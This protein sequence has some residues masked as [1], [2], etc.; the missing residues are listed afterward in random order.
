MIKKSSIDG[1]VQTTLIE[2]SVLI[3]VALFGTHW[4]RFVGLDNTGQAYCTGPMEADGLAE[5]EVWNHFQAEP[6]NAAYTFLQVYIYIYVCKTHVLR[7]HLVSVWTTGLRDLAKLGGVAGSE[8]QRS[9]ARRPF[10]AFSRLRTLD[11]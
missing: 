6:K 9:E 7:T 2:C 1:V 5:K 8:A 3:E 4:K 11:S 10:R